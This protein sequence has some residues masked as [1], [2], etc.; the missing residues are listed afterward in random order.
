MKIPR[1][2]L[3]LLTVC[4]LYSCGSAKQATTTIVGGDYNEKKDVTEY[5]VF[6]YGRVSIPGK[7][8]K[9]TYNSYSR[10]QFFCNDDSVI[11]A[12][13]FGTIDKFEFNSD[14][15][16][17]GY[18]FVK[19]YYK[20]EEEYFV[21]NGLECKIL[22]SDSEKNYIVFKAFGRGFDTVLLFGEKNGFTSNFSVNITDK[23]TEEQKVVF[24]K[25]LFIE[26]H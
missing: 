24:L 13:A 4:T 16:I 22:D 25:S 12:I 20:W 19:A 8:E 15:L 17:K 5:F 10:Q 18:E 7:W 23:W 11:I 26:D 2:F 1:L 6:P 21:N 9:T 3:I 14:G